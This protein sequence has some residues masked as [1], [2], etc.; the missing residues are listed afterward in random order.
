[1]VDVASFLTCGVGCALMMGVGGC[2]VYEMY[3]YS[4]IHRHNFMYLH[5]GT[6]GLCAVG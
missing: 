5:G 2:C 1:M 6:G 4:I 3:L